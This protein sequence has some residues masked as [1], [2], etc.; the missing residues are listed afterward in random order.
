EVQTIAKALGKLNVNFDFVATSPLKRSLQTAEIVADTMKL[1]KGKLEQ[2]NEL[3]PEGSRLELYRKLS[4]FKQ[5]SSVLVVGHEPYL[6][7]IIGEIAFGNGT[8]GIVLKKSGLAKI[9]LTALQP[10]LKG[11]LRWLLT[12]RHLKKLSK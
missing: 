4:Q 2:W 10:K 7:T 12:P 11:E 6:T 8:G 3:K 5:Q 1:K 9:G